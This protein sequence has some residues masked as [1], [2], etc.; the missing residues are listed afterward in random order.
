[1]RAIYALS[2]G[3]A[4]AVILTSASAQ[5]RRNIFA[6]PQNLQVLPADISPGE[7]SRIM[8]GNALG[9]GVRCQYCHVGEE[10]RSV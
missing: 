10:G 9:L 5:E 2:V 3:V 6:D 4:V 8:R 1:M 7:L